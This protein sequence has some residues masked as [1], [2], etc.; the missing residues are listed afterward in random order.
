M[1]AK[2]PKFANKIDF[3][4]SKDI[5]LFFPMNTDTPKTKI[6]IIIT[7]HLII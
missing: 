1:A 3:F 7:I 6:V 5:F 4:F 2:I